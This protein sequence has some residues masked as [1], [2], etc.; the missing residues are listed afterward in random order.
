MRFCFCN[1]PVFSTD[2][3]TRIGYCKSHSYMRTDT[4]KRSITQRAIS[5]G[6]PSAQL[7]S[8]VR[9][10]VKH[11][12]KEMG[13][14]QSLINDLDRTV[15]LVVRLK[16][17]DKHGINTCFTSGK[18]LHYKSLQAGHFIPRAHLATRWLLEN[19]RP[20]SEFENCHLSGNIEVFRKKLE[21]ENPGIT[22]WLQEQAREVYK[23]S[24]DE[25]KQLLLSMRQKLKMLES[26]LIINQ[27]VSQ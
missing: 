17:A 18:V 24:Q 12:D 27:I 21:E 8:K 26:K 6:K 2:K 25:L 1:Q 7:V 13:T 20:Q 5:K 11:E 14:M 22:D 23:P 19:I 10:L 3:N 9:N 15:S 16:E 4:D